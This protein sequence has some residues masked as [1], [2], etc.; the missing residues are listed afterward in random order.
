MNVL[1]YRYFTYIFIFVVTETEKQ[2][3]STEN[4]MSIAVHLKQTFNKAPF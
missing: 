1:D 3:E 2:S 4:H